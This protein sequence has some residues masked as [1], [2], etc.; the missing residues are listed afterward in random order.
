MISKATYLNMK[1]S[2]AQYER[3]LITPPTVINQPLIKEEV[4][5]YFFKYN[6]AYG[7]DRM[8]LCGYK[9]VLHF[10]DYDKRKDTKC[11][12]EDRKNKSFHPQN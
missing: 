11:L 1:R 12:T 9:Y 8:C 6:P 3:E 7:D 5:N 4:V 2:I 10:E